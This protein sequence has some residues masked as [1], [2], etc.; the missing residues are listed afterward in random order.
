MTH[1]SPH[2]TPDPWSTAVRWSSI[3]VVFFILYATLRYNVLRGVSWN[4]W[5][6]YIGNKIL[7]MAAVVILALSYLLGPLRRVINFDTTLPHVR[8]YLGLL[9]YGLAGLHAIVS[10]L[11][12]SPAYYPRLFLPEGKLTLVGELSML[13]GVLAFGLFGIIA[14]I[15]IPS[16]AQSLDRARW[17]RI[18]RSGY[19][20][21]ALVGLHVAV[22]GYGGWMRASAYQYGVVP[23]S[24][25][26]VIV[27]VVTLLARV[28]SAAFPLSRTG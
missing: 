19:L 11:I 25:I 12:F 20:G 3:I 22:M 27:V 26:A 1:E 4:S 23:L 18:Q 9:G 24:L 21:L 7:A 6:L 16:I 10:V 8:K 13:L 28:I 17:Q 14:V 2:H 5:P 15:S